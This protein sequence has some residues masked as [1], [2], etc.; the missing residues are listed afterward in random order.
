[1]QPPQSTAADTRLPS[2]NRRSVVEKALPLMRR[3]RDE[4]TETVVICAMAGRRGV[5][6]DHVP[7]LHS[8]R[9]VV[10]A[11]MTF[12]LHASAP[13]STDTM[14]AHP[15]FANWKCVTWKRRNSGNWFTGLTETGTGVC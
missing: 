8:F 15:R 9:F 14:A 5:V 7:A 11:G 2:A 3:L 13:P 12:T 1:M 6:L 10:D 4:T